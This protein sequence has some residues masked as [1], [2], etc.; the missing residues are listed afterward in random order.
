M[1]ARAGAR[2]EDETPP[3]T[4]SKIDAVGFVYATRETERVQACNLCGSTDSV[5]VTQ[6]DRYGFPSPMRMCRRCGLGFL[7]PRM[8][9]REYEEFYKSVYH[10]L[11][12]SLRGKSQTRQTR[13]TGLAAKAAKRVRILQGALPQPP[14]SA[15][16][17]GGGSGIVA[18]AVR[19]AFACETA[20][21]DPSPEDLRAAADAGLETFLGPAERFDPGA[22]RWDLVLLCRTIDHLLDISGSLASLHRLTA[23]GGHAFVDFKDVML[24]ARK[25]GSVE[26]AVGI[27]HPYYLTYETARAFL[28][29]AG[30]TP[31]Q[32]VRR[33]WFV[34][35]KTEPAE[36][37]WDQLHA[38][39]QT[40]LQE[41]QRLRR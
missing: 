19:A 32:E 12:R 2:R 4:L 36:P 15:L 26:A 31:I 39:A 38:V 7:S 20:V 9:A 41:L 8:T 13:S 6:R 24:V 40:N 25:R 16:D 21:L 5:E 10:P 37:D 27:E 34:L 23:S 1:N 18:E 3:A 33:R 11:T 14:S 22:R 35:T 17:V 30:F 28:T 29:Q